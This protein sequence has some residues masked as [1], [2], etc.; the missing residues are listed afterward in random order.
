MKSTFEFTKEEVDL[1]LAHAKDIAKI[2][3][4]RWDIPLKS[5][6]PKKWWHFQKG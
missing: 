3:R 2:G 4:K 6:R 1:I 5:I